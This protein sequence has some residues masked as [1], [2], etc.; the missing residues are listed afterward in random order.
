MNNP[1]S[2]H[3]ANLKP[4]K[5]ISKIW[6]LP[7]LAAI[8]GLGMVYK[9]WS[10]QGSI[11]QVQ[12]ETAEGLVENKTQVKYRDVAVGMV[13]KISF[14]QDRQSIL[15]TIEISKEMSDLLLADTQFWVV[16]PRVGAQGVS[17]IGTLL[18]GSYIE[19]SPGTEGAA[20]S[21]YIG[22]EFPPLTPPNADGIHLTLSSDGGRSLSVGNPVLFRGFS[23]GKIE[24]VEFNTQTRS[25]DYQIFVKA[26][27]D[28]LI[29]TNTYFWNASGLSLKADAN[30]VEVELASIESLLGGGIT[31][32]V[33]RDLSFGEVITE[34]TTFKLYDSYA[35]VLDR[36]EYKGFEYAILID[37]SVGGLSQGA[38]VE[39]KGIRIGSVSE[40]YI[41]FKE[42]L[43][44][45]NNDLDDHRIPI[46][47][48]IEPGRIYQ[49]P[50]IDPSNFKEVIEDGIAEGL[51]A[52][53]E[54][55]NILTGSLKV[56]L[57]FIGEPN[58][59]REQYQG[60]PVIPA[61]KGGFASLG[62]SVQDILDKVADLPFARTVENAN[63]VLKSSDQAIVELN[64]SL[65]ELQ[66]TMRGV[67]P[68]SDLYR[69]L[70]ESM[71][72][73]RA[74]LKSVQPVLKEISN[75]PNSLIF[76]GSKQK[77]LE[78]KAANTSE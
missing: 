23:V 17:G 48:Q 18:S 63:S 41:K 77:D 68:N 25:A 71:R 69:S 53:I 78:P 74:T 47:L 60:Y 28:A 19:L 21:N 73:L 67:Q 7:F 52:S 27:F 6:I 64:E 42:G 8:I 16:K 50:D 4:K 76:G 14:S 29:S 36:H 20:K 26:P 46:I 40:P 9:E 57:D 1:S 70:D 10:N 37:Q 11:I 56:T 65:R 34:P 51:V 15:L 66:H 72:E 62:N 75:K 61:H 12:F 45:L 55:G 38:P 5:G 24:A 33:P 43:S 39:Y 49:D 35:A 2:I 13:E 58:P 59:K 54:S 22:L 44:S 30:G 32:D 3:K 31:F